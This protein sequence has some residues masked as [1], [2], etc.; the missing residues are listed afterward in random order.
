MPNFNY[1]KAYCLFAFQSFQSLPG[2]VH[3][4]LL[5]LVGDLT[6][7]KD[8]SIPLS[9]E[10]ES[11]L[12]PLT[13]EE[14][15]HL[16]RA[17]YFAGHWRPSLLPDLFNTAKGESWKISNCCDQILRTRL[18]PLPHNIQIHEGKLRVTFSNRHCWIWE[19]FALAT[20]KNLET[21]KS[22][23]LPFGVDTLHSSAEALKSQIGDL[24]PIDSLDS[25]PDNDLY[26]TYLLKAQEKI[27]ADIQKSF[28]QK[29]KDLENAKITAQ[30][31]IEFLNYCNDRFISIENVIYY[32]H[33][34]CFTFGWRQPLPKTE[35]AD[36]KAKLGSDCPYNVEFKEV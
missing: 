22:S 15:A 8:L 7:G 12:T 26:K 31:E 10:I 20:E 11:L 5:P 21:F 25:L 35:A 29:I 9:P 2:H 18:A 19:E 28:D 36:I 27:K 6:Q 32:K 4:K 30:K 23:P 17:S 34:D 13:T 24:W 3:S 1:Q 16:S 33:R 14:I